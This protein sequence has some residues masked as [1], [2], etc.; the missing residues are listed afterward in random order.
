MHFRRCP[1]AR[2]L[3]AASHAR[4][5]LDSCA[6][7]RELADHGSLLLS[8]A[9]AN[10]VEHTTSDELRLVIQHDET[11]GRLVCAVHDDSAD[12]P[13]SEGM[14]SGCAERESG[15]GLAI[16]AALSLS[17]GFSTDGFGTWMW[18]CLEAS[19]T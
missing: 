1:A 9:V 6:P 3:Q 4:R 11:A 10:A 2:P 16:I 15:R 17:W 7:A 12:L 8:E 5:A 19:A 18:F 13:R 14:V